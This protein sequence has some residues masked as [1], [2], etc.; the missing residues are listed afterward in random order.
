[1]Y[2]IGSSLVHICLLLT[3]VIAVKFPDIEAAKKFDLEDKDRILTQIKKYEA[4]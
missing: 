2:Y 3:I 1:M 4:N